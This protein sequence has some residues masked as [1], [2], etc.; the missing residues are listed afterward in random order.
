MIDQ[1]NGCIVRAAGKA[2]FTLSKG[3]LVAARHAAS[4]NT[5]RFARLDQ[6]QAARAK[7]T[8]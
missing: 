5:Q 4:A 1:A 8:L 2:K 3:T 7:N 6:D